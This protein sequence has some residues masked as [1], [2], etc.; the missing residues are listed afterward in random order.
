MPQFLAN[1]PVQI[2]NNAK[3]PVLQLRGENQPS[4]TLSDDAL[5]QR[6]ILNADNG[7]LGMRR[8]RGD[9]LLGDLTVRLAD[10][11]N[12]FLGGGDADGD[13]VLVPAGVAPQNL[14]EKL[15]NA[16]VHLD[17]GGGNLFLGGHA[18]DGDVVLVPKGVA[19]K[20]ENATIH[21]NAEGD[22]PVLR[23]RGA[24]GQQSLVMWLSGESN[25][26]LQI[27]GNGRDGHVLIYPST[28]PNT[29]PGSMSS[30]S[31]S[32]ND[33][34]I[35]VRSGGQETIR[36]DGKK[37][38]IILHN[39]D[40]AEEFE[41]DADNAE[42]GSVLVIEDETRLQLADCPYDR[43][44]AGIVSGAAGIR[45]GI[46]LGR[47]R[48]GVGVP[49]ALFGR[50]NCRVDASYEPV[51][52]GDLLTTSETPGH[53][54]RAEPGDHRTLGAVIGKALCALDSGRGLVPV[55]AALQ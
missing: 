18:A 36:I 1:D 11:G 2:L 3:A 13:V 50:V 55:L 38:D 45:P 14:A 9:Q 39:A 48:E 28:A 44:V 46:I 5:S 34:V 53:A 49:V 52:A 4:I 42:P 32:G 24:N 22:T 6:I 7:V 27:G 26:N 12:L 35:S 19:Q 31:L 17:S 37:G 33:S 25:A 23:M 15:E 30:I 51:V 43:R 40:G 20:T 41:V 21:L 47:G 8:A 16:T 29:A 54:M 10:D